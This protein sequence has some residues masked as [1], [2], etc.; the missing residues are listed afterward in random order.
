MA[1]GAVSAQAGSPSDHWTVDLHA[2]PFMEEGMGIV[3]N[4]HF[5]QPLKAKDWSALFSSE[6]N[7]DALEASGDGIVVVTLYAHPVLEAPARAAIRR[8]LAA[9]EAYVAAHKNWTIAR[10]PAQA[11]TALSAGKRVMV[12]AL[13]R[14]SKVLETEEDL[15]EFVDKGG[16]RI[17][18]LLHLDDDIYGGVA[19]M[20]GFK[21]AFNPWAWLHSVFAPEYDEH[22]KINPNGLSDRGRTFLQALINRK[23]WVDLTHASEKS[24]RNAIPILLA[25]NQPLLYTHVPLRRYLGTERGISDIKIAEVQGSH[26]IVGVLPAEDML[27]GTP[28][29][30]EFCPKD[31]KCEGSVA[32]FAT[33]Y[34]EFVGMLGPSSVM[35]GSDFNGGIAHLKP[36]CGTGTELDRKAGLWNMGQ[37]AALWQALENVGAP[38]PKRRADMID[39]FLEAWDRVVR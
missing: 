21:R 33:Q 9:A 19:F 37:T 4:G 15:I 32:A 24:Q 1:L 10:S 8:Q 25:A 18:T 35:L 11:R 14:A 2:H 31:C 34:A 6:I 20:S 23:V 13:E 26:G 27:E 5:D 36:A 22:I 17:V 12:L 38:V 28:I 39:G 3:F 7:S 30:S 16:I 29:K